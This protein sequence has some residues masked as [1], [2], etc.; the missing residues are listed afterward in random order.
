MEKTQGKVL[1]DKRMQISMWTAGVNYYA[2]PNLVIKADYSNRRVG[3]GNYNSEN[4]ISVG[5]AYIGWFLTK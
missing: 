3:G 5:I 2:L 1:A 4:M